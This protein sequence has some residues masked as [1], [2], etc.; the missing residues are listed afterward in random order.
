MDRWL[1]ARDGPRP[2]LGMLPASR[3]RDAARRDR[4]LASR[5][6]GRNGNDLPKPIVKPERRN[7][8]RELQKARPRVAANW[9]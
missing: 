3:V 7:S 4:M 6:G 1:E 2:Q 8:L 5:Y 9:S